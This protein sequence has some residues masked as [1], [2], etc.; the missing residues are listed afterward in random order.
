MSHE[1]PVA[2]SEGRRIV[3]CDYNALLLSV[4]GLLRM[5]GYTVFQAH[6]G[7]AAQELC[8]LLPNIDLL[9]L[10]TYGTG[11]DV[12]ELC[13]SV[14]HA[15]RALPI[16]HIGSTTPP[17]LPSDVPTLAE[18]FTADS[19]LLTVQGLIEPALKRQDPVQP[20]TRNVERYPNGRRWEDQGSRTA[21]PMGE[22]FSAPFHEAARI[23]PPSRMHTSWTA[24]LW[25]RIMTSR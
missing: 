21:F 13:R 3:I 14:R 11:I 20:P 19:L 23:G 1:F 10:N 5:S 6:D 2:P 25:H 7:W 18:Q 8:L 12:S 17:G 24:R 15:K 9:V 4:T 22:P 16:L